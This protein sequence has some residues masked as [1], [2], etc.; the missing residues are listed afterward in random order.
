MTMTTG[1]L[2]GASDVRRIASAI[3]V[4]PTKKLGQN[5]VIDP[6]TVRKIVRISDV[7]S[8]S[9]VIE[10]G[11]GLG[12]LTLAL[13]ETGCHVAA[14]EIDPRLG[15]QLPLTVKEFMPSATERLEVIIKDALTLTTRDLPGS[16]PIDD[17]DLV[18]NLP[19][20]VATPLVLT[21]LEQ[22]PG[23]RRFT[24]MVQKEMADRMVAVPGSKVYGAPSAKLAW[25]G[26]AE[27]AGI[28]GRNVFWP[29]PNVDS[30]LV[31]FS[32]H[33]DG[34]RGSFRTDEALRPDV[35]AV[36]DAA[37]GQRRKTLGHAL[38]GIVDADGFRKS[39]IDP[40]RRGETLTI[41]EFVA[42]AHQM[43]G[44]PHAPTVR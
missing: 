14:V 16:T 23:L 30:A 3:G 15:A 18:A 41:E 36:I 28:I 31:S 29:A 1:R 2:L 8:Q 38:R 9:F 11:P 34:S 22:F 32:R 6:G 42:L 37:F 33:A 20:N 39:G 35:F 43:E 24:V 7:S 27:R 26:H 10:V 12:S 44:G 19:Y 17:V 25:F 21:M 5:F 4:S 13:L 40:C